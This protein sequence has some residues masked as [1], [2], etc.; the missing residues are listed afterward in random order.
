MFAHVNGLV[1]EKDEGTLVIDCGGVGYQLTVSAATLAEAPPVG[2]MMKCYTWLS[3]RE[4]AMELFG[5]ATREEK[6]MF[7][8]LTA[9]SGIGPRSAL[10]ALSSRGAE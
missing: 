9:V 8:K 7:L 1:A 6:R 10:Q 5:F 3:V 2:E 4:D